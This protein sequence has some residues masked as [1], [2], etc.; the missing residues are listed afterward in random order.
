M[1]TPAT[2]VAQ[3]LTREQCI[4]ILSDPSTPELVLR[5]AVASLLAGVAVA[6]PVAAAATVAAA[7]GKATT[8]K[9]TT[10]AAAPAPAPAGGAPTPEAAIVALAPDGFSK[11]DLAAL[12]GL[13]AKA[14]ALNTAIKNALAAKTIHS[15]GERRF[16][17]YGATAAIAKACSQAAQKGDKA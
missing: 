12:T 6:S 11:G 14:S 4:A 9:A 5:G 15:A 1:T 13:D 7:K 8:P 16:M 3:G 2:L 17:R 10:T